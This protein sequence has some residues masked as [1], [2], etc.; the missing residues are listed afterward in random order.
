VI[1]P[2]DN[3][4]RP[5]VE[6][7]GT[8]DFSIYDQSIK[9]YEEAGFEDPPIL[10]MEGLMA[11]IASAMGK[12]S[13]LKFSDNFTPGVKAEEVP[14]DVREFAGRVIRRIYDHSLEAKWPPFYI[15]FADEPSSGSFNM[16]KA[17]FMYGLARKVAPEM[18]TAGTAYTLEDWRELDHLLD[19]NIINYPNMCRKDVLLDMNEEYLAFSRE[20]NARMY[21]LDWIPSKD[22]FW[23]CR[24]ITLTVEKGG[25]D[26]IMCWTQWICGGVEEEKI[27]VTEPFDPYMFLPNTWKGGPWFMPGPDGRVWR[28]LPWLGIREGIDDSRYLRTLHENIEE[29]EESGKNEVAAKASMVIENVLNEVAW[30][31]GPSDYPEWTAARADAARRKLADEAIKLLRV[32][33]AVLSK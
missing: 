29:A 30:A 9:L 14:A 13:E 20:Q 19:L 32:G 23:E 25:M 8:V 24:R 18:Q 17:K 1:S 28:S 11:A 15:Y 6:K 5:G 22:T 16:E 2:G 33:S 12:T 27:K 31:P 21:G 4:Q 3:Q 26:G 10:A 7:D